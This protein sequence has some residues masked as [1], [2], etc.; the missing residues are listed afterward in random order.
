MRKAFPWITFLAAL[1]ILAA[2][3]VYIQQAIAAQQNQVKQQ[4]PPAPQP[5]L[6]VSV[7]EVVTTPHS[8]RV[9]LVGIA[10]PRYELTLTSQVSGEVH[11]LGKEYE[12]G[13]FIKQG[14]VL[15][16]LKNPELIANLASAEN[17]VANA[18]LALKEEER[19]VQQ[20]QAEWQAAGLTGQ[21]SSELVLR[22]PQLA[23]ARAALKAA[24]ANLQLARE[25]QQDLVIRAPFDGVITATQVAPGQYINANTT[26]ATIH[27]ADYAMIELQPS[28]QDW[29]KLPATD[30][31]VEQRWPAQV[32]SVDSSATWRGFVASV[33][34]HLDS[35]SR[36]RSL[37][38]RVDAPF[39]QVQP[40]LSGSYVSVQLQ[41]KT[42][43]G[44]WQLPNSSLSQKSEIWYVDEKQQLKNFAASPVFVD[45][46]FIYIR[47]P[48]QLASQK[49]QVLTHP[50]NSYLVGT[51]VR[52]LVQDS[53]ILVAGQKQ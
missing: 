33:S 37:F 3:G 23:A 20:A 42:I 43:D 12:V 41:G 21:P 39:D 1:A 40:L 38:V 53:N 46:R 25:R 31:M 27:S 32:E 5:P 45:N 18:E 8:A 35:N 9:N 49:Q 28:N 47:P 50:Y 16:T 2:A 11:S 15:I 6:E 4:R 26:V 36:L 48:V 13:R 44:L 14:T 7:V 52:P 51:K 24:Q 10:H 19:Q 17:S 30:D 34:Q 29:F 22:K